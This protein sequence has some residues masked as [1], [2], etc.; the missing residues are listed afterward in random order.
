MISDVV[1]YGATPGAIFAAI[2]LARGGRT[3]AMVTPQYQVGGMLTGGLGITDAPNTRNWWG[4]VEEFTTALKARTGWANDRLSWNCAPSDALAVFTAMLAAH[5]GITVR[6]NEQLVSVRKNQGT[7]G[8]G[9]TVASADVVGTR[10]ASITTAGGIY[11]GT[12]FLDATYTGELMA[13]A[14]V[15]HRVGR[16]SR[17]RYRELRA[18][19]L[20]GSFAT[21]LDYDVVD[22][23]GDLT[24]YGQFRPR[25]APGE[26]DRRTMAC[27]FR[28][29]ITNVDDIGWPAPP[30][31]DDA[32]FQ[33]EIAYAQAR[34]PTLYTRDFAFFLRRA[35]YDPVAAAALIPG[36]AG[37]TP[38]GKQEAWHAFT[39]PANLVT[40][41]GKCMTNG[42]DIIG[43]LAWE[44]AIAPEW[45][46]AEIEEQLL[47][48]E[49]GRFHTFA[50]HP[51]VPAATR[52]SFATMGLCGD[53]WAGGGVP[54]WPSEL[55]HREGRRIEGQATVDLWDHVYQVNWPDQIAFGGYF[56]DSKAKTQYAT[57]FGGAEREGSYG[58][59]DIV[60]ADG[61]TIALDDYRYV[62]IPMR[63]VIAEPGVCD[64]LAVTWGISATEIAFS[65]IRLEPFLA[66]VA[67]AVGHMALESLASAVPM[68]RLD[69]G[70]VRSRLNAAGA[71]LARYGDV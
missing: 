26:S 21:T 16:E 36:F 56:V 10:I 66:A 32:D 12:V 40:A 20:A 3:V 2:V 11:E 43:P 13:M 23:D 34:T 52:N 49:L 55:Y 47:Y 1:I 44:Y 18:G 9:Q 46:R 48:R 54:G 19:V 27:G 41:P 4:V 59:V 17:S 63:A 24:R 35:H 51:D 62:G 8:P 60:T 57:P 53:E 33:A 14:G 37:M 58:D 68:A 45:R 65:A 5:P 39:Q 70:R 6:T 25:Q 22:A 71:Q 15:P 7:F 31:Y 29:A 64:N 61:E 30:G 42:S 28:H 67:E 69:Y 50:T 38:T